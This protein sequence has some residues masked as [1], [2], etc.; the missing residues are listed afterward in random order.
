MPE[1]APIE[2]ETTPS[3]DP[4]SYHVSSQK[5]A[6]KLGYVPSH[7]IEDAVRD[8]CRAFKAGKLQNSFEDDNYFNVKTVKNLGLK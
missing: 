8:I 3:N 5:I 4:R 7:S 2:I 6:D 1:L